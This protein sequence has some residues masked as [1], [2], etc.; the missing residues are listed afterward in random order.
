MSETPLRWGDAETRDTIDGAGAEPFGAPQS[1]PIWLHDL[2][3]L[4]RATGLITIEEP[5]WETRSR[6]SGGYITGPV[7][8]V[9]HHTA[10]GPASDGQA[11]VD[12]CCYTSSIRPICGL[13][14]AR[15]GR[16]WVC[17]AGATNHAGEGGPYGPIPVDDANR[18]C[19]GI[20]AANTGVGEPWPTIQQD[21]YVTLVRALCDH[22][23]ISTPN[24]LSH[25]L[26]APSRKIDPAGPA[27]FTLTGGTWDMD[28]F[29]A[30]V[31]GAPT[32]PEPTPTPPPN[33]GTGYPGQAQTY[34]RGP[35]VL[36]WQ[37]AMIW[38]G[39]IADTP[40]N[41]D[42]FYGDGMYG[43]VGRMQAGFGWSDC[44]GVA[45]PHTWDH[46]VTRGAPPCPRCG[47]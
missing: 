22:Y 31:I 16:V 21:A 5:G 18:R 28:L 46:M 1:A 47:K 7:G 42:S 6:Q 26:W 2:A 38:G 8:I 33:T 32:P 30:E 11:D 43:A 23:A 3:E 19:I 20:E 25:A 39:W 13:Y 10:S 40:A 24:V 17:A 27:R 14:L 15:D 37:E 41:R 36:E 34:D 29:R 4:V 44:D 45:G 12:Y 9:V 35:V